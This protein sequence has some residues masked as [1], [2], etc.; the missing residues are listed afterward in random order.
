[1]RTIDAL[2]EEVKDLNQ[3]WTESYAKGDSAFLQRYLSDDY[4]STYPDGTVLDKEG[5][6]ESVKSGEVS[7]TEIP[8][9][10]NVRVYGE[11]A[12]ITGRSTLKAK[13]KG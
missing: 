10:L 6:I 1:M 7:F 5:E 12:V 4:L 9:E 3:L 2:K 8:R 13:V 11:A